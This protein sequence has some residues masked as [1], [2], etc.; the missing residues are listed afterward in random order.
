MQQ[1]ARPIIS[2]I[3]VAL[4][5]LALTGWT[6][7]WVSAQSITTEAI[8]RLTRQRL[9]AALD[10][11][12]EFL[13]IPND[14]NYPAQVEA[15]L[16]WC[17]DR[18]TG[19]GFE[20]TR[21]ETPEMP[22]LFARRTA[23]PDLPTVLFYLQIDGQPVDTAAWD[24][25][26]PYAATWKRKEA[27]GS[28]TAVPVPT[29]AIDDELRL[30]ARSASDSKGPAVAFISALDILR[31]EGIEPAYN[32]SVIMDFQEEL[33]SDDLPGAVAA[34]RESFGAEF[35]VI[36]DGTRHVSNLPTLTFGARGIATVTLRIF[37]PAYPLHSG[38]YGNFAPNPVFAAARLIAG[39]KDEAGRVL[40]PGFYEGVTLTDADREAMNQVPETREEIR[41]MV[42]VAENE[43]IGD[44]Y[45]EAL[46]YPSLNVRGLR[47]GWTGKE[48]RTLIPE[49]VI[50]EIDMRLVAETPGA[51]QVELLR[52]YIA[53]A[54][55]HFVD[56]I[57]SEAERARYPRLIHF[58]HSLGSVPFRTDLGTPIDA[59]LT[60]AVRRGLATEPVRMRTTGGSQPMGPFVNLLGLPA[61]SLRIPN[62]DNS[63]HA[64]NENIRVGN[65]RE[66]LSACLAVL[67]Q[68]LSVK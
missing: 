64:P 39:M 46:Q 29:D 22:L 5:L 28:F 12:T 50:V 30:F 57:P 60:A 65:F 61:V 32:V 24:Q 26:D 55:Y 51:R 7:G 9:P 38:Q 54:G 20:V 36:M 49:D 17:R 31:Q 41:A 14:G 62:P 1:S 27:D 37:G 11:L 40:I 4:L 10:E 21:L 16:A 52:K 58:S 53:D 45:Q 47:A 42:G 63:I 13:A 34:H 18:F 2:R 66:G 33:G 68:P 23:D 48:V 6:T 25:P 59:W 3:T 43:S 35:L 15:N 56:S 8:D 67:T 44:T 19:L